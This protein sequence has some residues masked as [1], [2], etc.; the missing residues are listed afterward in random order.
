MKQL[1]KT[2]L[3]AL[4]IFASGVVMANGNLKVSI[5]QGAIDEAV[6]NISN[7][8]NS[9]FEIQ[10]N[11]ENGN[12]IFYKITQHPSTN[13]SNVYDFSRLDDGLY[14]FMVNID[15]EQSTSTLKV[16]NGNLN[17]I[18][19]NK[20]VDP[21]FALNNDR[22]EIAYLNFD[23]RDI[24]LYV[25]ESGSNRLLHEEELGKKFVLNHALDLSKLR[26]GAYDAVLVS[27]L[28]THQYDFKID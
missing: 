21:F 16:S 22:L 6:V 2:T 8:V 19:Q 20:E 23:Q 9:V 17:V 25:Y 11:D 5:V 24:K 7:A 3:I 15:N 28:A 27:N 18:E 1:M 12:V 26:S 10:V 4:L 14:S 13:Y